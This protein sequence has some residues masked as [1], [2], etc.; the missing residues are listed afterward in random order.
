MQT[1][2]TELRLSASVTSA[3]A[4]GVSHALCSE[5]ECL[6]DNLVFTY[7]LSETGQQ[8]LGILL[9]PPPQRWDFRH[10]LPHLCT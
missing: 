5:S 4:P 2:G 1:P 6:T 8:A 3:F 10:V 7:E 9:S